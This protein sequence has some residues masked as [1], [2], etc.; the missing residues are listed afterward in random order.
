[1]YEQEVRRMAGTGAKPAVTYDVLM[2]SHGAR[3]PVA[4]KHLSALLDEE[5]GCKSLRKVYV[6]WSA[7]EPVPRQLRRAIEA[8]SSSNEESD[9]KGG[10]EDRDSVARASRNLSSDGGVESNQEI[11]ISSD[12]AGPASGSSSSVG[13]IVGNDRAALFLLQGNFTLNQRF[14]LPPDA[15]AGDPDQASGQKQ[16]YLSL[17]D[18]LDV[19]CE[20]LELAFA[21]QLA[22]PDRLVGFYP[23]TP[24]RLPGPARA[25]KY[26]YNWRHTPYSLVLTKAAFMPR[27]LLVR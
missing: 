3:G 11:N 9:S 1:M 21:A 2:P 12:S 10:Q 25:F 13:T 7:S 26:E 6:M 23:R 8:Y 16:F 17:D 27:E 22:S 4:A 18:D 19:P 24:W 5:S 15:D 20:L 14:L